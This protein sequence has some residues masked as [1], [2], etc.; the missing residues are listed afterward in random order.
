MQHQ[1]KLSIRLVIRKGIRNGAKRGKIAT[2]LSG[3]GEEQI[4]TL[5]SNIKR[6]T[7]G[8]DFDVNDKVWTF[9]MCV[10]FWSNMQSK[11]LLPIN[12]ETNIPHISLPIGLDNM[13]MK[14]FLPVIFD[15][16]AVVCV[17][18]FDYHLAL[19]NKYPQV[20]NTLLW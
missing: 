13:K 15:T 7:P 12:V 1:N 11:P 5:V 8:T 10:C 20:V 14:L 3:L 9:L 6:K 16:A 19:A 17:G 4:K 18:S 2:L